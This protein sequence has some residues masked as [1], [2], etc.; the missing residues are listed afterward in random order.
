M[1]L[2]VPSKRLLMHSQISKGENAMD[3]INRAKAAMLHRM[4]G[5]GWIIVY[6]SE[7]AGDVKK[8]FSYIQ[9]L[10]NNSRDVKLKDNMIV[11]DN[12][13]LVHWLKKLVQEQRIVPPGDNLPGVLMMHR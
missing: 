2:P 9:E 1:A 5:G 8:L 4:A 11:S 12:P 7:C 3:L 10:C 13:F 6:E